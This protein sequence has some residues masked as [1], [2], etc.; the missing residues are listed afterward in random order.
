M[1]SDDLKEEI[2]RLNF[3]NGS[4][5]N[6]RKRI[7]E[8]EKLIDKKSKTLTQREEKCHK[9][10]KSNEANFNIFVENR[11][12]YLDKCSFELDQK[13][14]VLEMKEHDLRERQ[15]LLEMREHDFR[16]KQR[17]L[18][19]REIGLKQHIIHFETIYGKQY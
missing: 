4:L 19:M 5:T 8:H 1:N 14:K 11:M 10:L 9:I 18:E 7:Q 2:G 6:K 15:R 17:L 12:T 16:E 3:I 13:Q